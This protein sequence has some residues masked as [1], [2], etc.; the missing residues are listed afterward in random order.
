M[1][2]DP[3]VHELEVVPRGATLVIPSV[4]LSGEDGHVGP[5]G[6]AEAGA[7]DAFFELAHAAVEVVVVVRADIDVYP[8]A[9]RFAQALG[10][11]PVADD[12]VRQVRADL[13]PIRDRLG[14]YLAR[15]FVPR[16]QG[17]PVQALDAEDRVP[18]VP[19]QRGARGGPEH[20]FPVVLLRYC[21]QDDFGVV[22]V[23]R[24]DRTN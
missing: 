9:Q 3:P 10:A 24:A 5:A 19:L 15:H 23:K 21:R 17:V 16:L 6:P 12:V 4:R 22:A 1:V 14:V 13:L 18:H 2:A 7:V 20:E 11:A 8:A